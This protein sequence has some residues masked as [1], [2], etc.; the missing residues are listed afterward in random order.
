MRAGLAKQVA[1]VDGAARGTGRGVDGATRGASRDDGAAR[2]AGR[3]D[4]AAWRWQ[5]RQGRVWCG[6]GR[7]GRAWNGKRRERRRRGRTWCRQRRKAGRLGWWGNRIGLKEG[8]EIGGWGGASKRKHI[9]VEDEVT[10][11]DDAV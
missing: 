11:D 3:V 2:G 1:L 7:R 4:E 5:D 9:F 8:V 10:R 6:Q